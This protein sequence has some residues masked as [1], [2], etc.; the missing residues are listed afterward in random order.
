MA[1][2]DKEFLDASDIESANTAMNGG[3]AKHTSTC[4]ENIILE[5]AKIVGRYGRSGSTL[6]GEKR[7]R[8]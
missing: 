4:T 3:L 8:E 2:K 6:K 1:F 7:T 5:N